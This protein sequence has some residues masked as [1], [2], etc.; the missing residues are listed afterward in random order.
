MHVSMYQTEIGINTC[1]NFVNGV[2]V[3]DEH[4]SIVVALLALND[5]DNPL[6]S[7]SSIHI[8]LRENFKLTTRLSGRKTGREG[9]RERDRRRDGERKGERDRGRGGGRKGGREEWRERD[10]QTEREG[11]REEGRERQRE[12]EEGRENN[13]SQ[14]CLCP[15]E[16]HI[17]HLS[18]LFLI[19]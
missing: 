9:G 17:C 2:E 14:K 5:R 1:T 3:R 4:I 7:H 18:L 6:Q 12:S 19:T 13:Y 11:G 15:N 10:R 8:L 16:I